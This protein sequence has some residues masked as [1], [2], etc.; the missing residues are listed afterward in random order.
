[1]V[2][3]NRQSGQSLYTGRYYAGDGSLGSA[4]AADATR[5]TATAA[6]RDLG[7]VKLDTC[8]TVRGRVADPRSLLMLSDEVTP[9]GISQMSVVVHNDTNPDLVTRSAPVGDDGTF[10]VTGLLPGSYYATLRIDEHHNLGASSGYRSAEIPFDGVSPGSGAPNVTVS[11]SCGEVKNVNFGAVQPPT[12]G[13][14]PVVPA[15]W[16]DWSS[17]VGFGPSRCVNVDQVG[18][19]AGVSGVLVNVTSVNPP[20]NGNAVVFPSDGS[21]APVAPVGSS[22]Q[23]EPGQ[24][25]AS[26]ALSGV[27]PDGRVCVASQMYGGSSRALM[28][29]SAFFTADSGV[30]LG[31]SRRVLDTRTEAGAGLA[32]RRV[33]EVQIGG[34]AGVPADAK[35]VVLS[36]TAVS[37]GGP[38]NL[39]VF[40]ATGASAVPQVSTVNYVPGVTK[41]NAAIVPLGTGGK[42]GLYSDTGGAVQVVLDVT[43]Y[44]AA[45]SASYQS[46]DPVRVLDTRPGAESLRVVPTLQANTPVAFDVVGTGKVPPGATSVVLNVTAIAPT[47]IGHLRV[48]PDEG[49]ASPPEASSI[50]YIPSP[51]RAIANLVMVKVPA[52]GKIML[53]SNQPAGSVD[54]A[55]DLVGYT[56]DP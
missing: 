42:V 28:D 21:S 35:A 18:A 47:S 48:Y 14:V 44:V 22:V 24:T 1:V 13:V 46:V 53:Y 15:R 54:L 56:T 20:G 31:A 5:V 17:V 40:P 25:V 11:A 29:V 39:R 19:P 51:D 37:P 16:A 55:I 34:V 36:V 41:A 12:S 10:A 50:N 49:L 30:V 7:T 23:F 32:S 52:N 6:A 4:K 9:D 33:R 2:A 45:G 38:G 8:G 43:G 27:G 26:A 3:V